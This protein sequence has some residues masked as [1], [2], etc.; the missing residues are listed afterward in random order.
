MRESA[1]SFLRRVLFCV[2]AFTS[3]P[4]LA[5]PTA[6]AQ[7]PD[8]AADRAQSFQAVQGAIKED[9][10]GGPLLVYAYGLIWLV[11]LLY[12]VRLAKLQQHN[13]RELERLSKVLERAPH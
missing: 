3:A 1:N 5:A 12:V 10:P 9:V 7:E 13:R 4:W 11:V 2:V 8:A 6:F